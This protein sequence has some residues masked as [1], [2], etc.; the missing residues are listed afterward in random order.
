MP[1]ADVVVKH[2]DG[3]QKDTRGI[4]EGYQGIGFHS[5]RPRSS[6]SMYLT[7]HLQVRSEVHEKQKTVPEISS[8]SPL[9]LL[10]NI[11]YLT[12]AAE[13]TSYELRMCVCTCVRPP[14]GRSLD[15]QHA[16]YR[17]QT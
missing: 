3:Y 2:H 6:Y 9:P 8:S 1:I 14:R 4:P 11:R 12:K 10:R 16:P 17:R 7:A 15:R 13:R 5:T